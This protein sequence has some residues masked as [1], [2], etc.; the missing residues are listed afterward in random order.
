M[1]FILD[2]DL[3]IVCAHATRC[4]IGAYCMPC[5]VCGPWVSPVQRERLIQGNHMAQQLRA[6]QR[7]I[8]AKGRCHKNNGDALSN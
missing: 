2:F 7:Y 4:F 8:T 6:P 5:S 1:D 3:I